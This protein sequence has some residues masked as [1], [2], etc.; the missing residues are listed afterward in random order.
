MEKPNYVLKTNEAVLFPK[1]QSKGF[2]VLKTGVAV[3]IL[4]IIVGSL[5]FQENLFAQLSWTPR[6]LLI[7]LVIGVLTMNGRKEYGPSPMELQFFDE[8]LILYLPKR[9]YNKRVTRMEINKMK[10]SEISKCVYKA[11][12]QR[13]HLYGDG[14][15]TWYNYKK[16][17]TIPQTPTKVNEYK[18]GLIYFGTRLAVD[19]DFKQ[20]IEAYSPIK[21]IVENS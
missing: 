20:E 7:T 5:L 21:V 6:V 15:S 3:V 13:I 2:V 8:Y 9:Y 14:I 11:E 16:D 19:V 10:Y 12:S 1:E 17:G 18:D 4:V